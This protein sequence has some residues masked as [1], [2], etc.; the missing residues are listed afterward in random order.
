VC[1]SEEKLQVHNHFHHNPIKCEHCDK[2]YIGKKNLHNH[3]LRGHTETKDCVSVQLVGSVSQQLF[4]CQ[5]IRTTFTASIPLGVE[6][7]QLLLN[8]RAVSR[9]TWR[10]I[11]A[12]KL[13]LVPVAN[14]SLK[15]KDI[16]KNILALNIQSTFLKLVETNSWKRLLLLLRESTSVLN[17]MQDLKTNPSLPVTSL[18]FTGREPYLVLSQ[19]TLMFSTDTYLQNHI[20]RQHS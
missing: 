1:W 6:T 19:C 10:H 16:C 2:S 3:I 5:D 9:I 17:A 18:Q 7:V 20:K 11:T 12:P 15:L 13:F 4:C 14:P 8:T